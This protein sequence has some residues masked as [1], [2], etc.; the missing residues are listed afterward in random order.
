MNKKAIISTQMSWIFILIA[1]AIILLF[2]VSIIQ[3]Q[4][5]ITEKSIDVGITQQ[6]SSI[7]NG[8][9]SEEKTS[10][11]I[12]MNPDI[13]IRLSCRDYRVRNIGNSYGQVIAFSPNEII[14]NNLLVW[15]RDFNLPFRISNLLYLTSDKARYIFVYDNNEDEKLAEEIFNM[16]PD[17][18]KNITEIKTKN[19]ITNIEDKNN[20]KVRFIFFDHSNSNDGIITGSI[21]AIK[22]NLKKTKNKDISFLRVIPEN[23]QLYGSLEFYNAKQPY[24]KGESIYITK[25]TLIGAIFSENIEDYR[26]S[27]KKALKQALILDRVY[28]NRTLTLSIYE[29]DDN[30]K[31]RL[32]ETL[33]TLKELKEK[34]EDAISIADTTIPIDK[35][36]GLYATAYEELKQNNNALKLHSCPLVY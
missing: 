3:K 18:I 31:V 29:K 17:N 13:K 27:L 26:C 32:N 9:V 34:L 10:S 28:I 8:I 15:S 36:E 24:S 21:I 22:N 11:S 23:S 5:D 35:I 16:L 12:R 30:C 6:I 20:Y 1:G 25:E 4:K 19:E 33:E 7:I 2:F 14:G